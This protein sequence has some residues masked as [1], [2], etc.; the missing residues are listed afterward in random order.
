MRRFLI[1]CNDGDSDDNTVGDSR[2]DADSNRGTAV[3]KLSLSMVMKM[4]KS[5]MVWVPS[6]TETVSTMLASVA[7]RRSTVV[8]MMPVA[9]D[10]NEK[11]QP[12]LR[13]Y[14]TCSDGRQREKS[15]L[16]TRI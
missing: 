14:N 12:Y 11:R 3:C 1:E 7:A 8:V 6:V 15:A 4:L 13:G 2:S 16:F 10:V 9:R 5:S